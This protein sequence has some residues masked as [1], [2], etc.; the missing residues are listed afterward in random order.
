LAFRVTAAGEG[1]TAYRA[2]AVCVPGIAIA[3]G[4]AL[5]PLRSAGPLSGAPF[6]ISFVLLLLGFV[7]AEL[8]SVEVESRNEAHSMN[9]VEFVYVAALAFSAPVAIVLARPLA[10]FF[11]M[12]VIR[13]QSPHK[14]LINVSVTAAEAAVVSVVFV[15]LIGDHDPVE[16]IGWLI[17]LAATV[18]GYLVSSTLVTTAISLF[19][20]FVDWTTI[21]PVLAVGAI[22]AL[23]NTAL[24]IVLV[25]SLWTKSHLGWLVLGVVGVLFLLYRA[26]TALSER[27]KRLETLHDFTRSLAASDLDELEGAVVNGAR[28]ILRGEQGV[29]LLPPPRDGLPAVRLL[30]RGHGLARFNISATELAA[31]LALL[32]PNDVSR[33]YIP[34]EPLPGWLAEIGVKD[35]VVVPLTTDG[36]TVGAMV[37]A[38]RLTEVSSFVEDDLR[39]FETLA[40]HANVALANGR[41]VATLQYDAQE[42]AHQALHDPVTGLPNRTLLQERLETAIQ[43]ARTSELGVALVFLDLVTFKEVNDTLGTVTG[44]RLLVEVRDRI[45]A[46]LPERAQLAQ[47]TGDQFAVLV[48]DVTDQDVVMGLAEAILTEFDS[49][50]TAGD[51]SLVLGADLGVAHYPDHAP[52]AELL[53]QRADA[54]TYRARQEGSGIEVYA[55][56]TDP[57]APRRL[58]L[59]ADLSE[60]LERDE[61]D[62]YVQ[63]K[64]R[65]GDGLIVGAEALVRWT[66]PR[67]GP[68]SPDQFIPAAEHTGVIRQLTTYV[69][70][71]ALAQCRSWRDAGLDLDI[72][73]NLSGRNLFDTHLVEDIGEAIAE[74]GVPASS[75]T[76][77]LT[78]STV[79]GES[80][81][82]MAVLLGLQE[83]GVRLSVDDFGTGYS[84]LA[85]LRSLPVTELKI[86]KSFVMTMTVNDQDAVIVRTLVELGRSLG[87]RTVA[88]GVESPDAQTMLRDYGCDEAQGYLFSRPIPAEQFVA[89]LG[90]QPARRRSHGEQV[91][92]FNREQRRAVGEVDPV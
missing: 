60:A 90:R 88:E 7:A 75:L 70:R 52:T 65:L 80:H 5:G 63:P 32:L 71:D 58:A 42:K 4:L 23:A 8:I 35:A 55:A 11:T 50:V 3:A 49:P 76:L 54:A 82:S 17:I 12:G 37:V 25:G 22:V 29:L 92:Q 10:S 85:H 40:N 33:L 41:L 16:P 43:A 27:H 28:E 89:W 81:R 15:T 86:D 18:A 9:F 61:V 69:V 44:D 67:L 59:A 83:L 74:A 31:D 14:L 1:K 39:L 62:V 30:S 21:A 26:H 84:S 78:E 53:L 87:L 47:F 72:S 48:T 56:E 20:G 38:N 46:L 24:G 45:Q 19:N 6:E 77:E 73:V 66:H 64:V 34:G 36:V 2:L 51:V 68:L 13:R 79:M 91:L 57:Y